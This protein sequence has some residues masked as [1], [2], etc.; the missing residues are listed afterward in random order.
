MNIYFNIEYGTALGEE[1][2]L[3][4]GE[5]RHRMSSVDGRH[6]WFNWEVQKA[7]NLEYTFC[8]ESG[9]QVTRREWSVVK[10]RLSL[11][12]GDITVWNRWNDFPEDSYRYSSA[13][14]ADCTL[15][16]PLVAGSLAANHTTIRLVVRAPQLRKGM[17]LKVVGD[18]EA[19]GRW[20][21]NKAIPMVQQNY[22]EWV[23]EV[24]LDIEQ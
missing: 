2:V 11:T 6:W 19:L 14:C 22:N 20:D 12:G 8:V 13:F 1:L 21:L 7:G 24:L 10:H 3:E 16:K 9:G 18:C 4:V 15:D 23:A 5:Y 17:S